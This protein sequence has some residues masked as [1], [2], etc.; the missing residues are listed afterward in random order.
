[1]ARLL[2][3]P[4]ENLFTQEVSTVKEVCLMAPFISS[5]G[6]D[7]LLAALGTSGVARV[8]TRL[9]D[10][11][12][13]SGV[14]SVGGLCRIVEQGSRVRA[15]NRRLHSKLYIFG[16]TSCVVT[17]SNLSTAGLSQ[18]AEIGVHLTRQA[19]IDSAKKHFELVWASLDPDTPL[20]EL[21]RIEAHVDL[22]QLRRG[23]R[24]DDP[25]GIVDHGRDG[26]IGGASGPRTPP[27]S[28]HRS[29][30]SSGR[31][32]CKFLWRR[33]DEA[34]LDTKVGLIAP[35]QG[36]VAFPRSGRPRQIKVNDHIYHTALTSTSRGRD[37]IVFGRARVAS[38]HRPGKDEAP[39]DLRRRIPMLD[40]YPYCIWL[41]DCEFIDGE[42]GDG[43]SLHD[44]FGQ[45][46]DST[47]EWS[48]KEA[49]E[50]RTGRHRQ[51]IAL[52][53]SHIALTRE[54]VATLNDEFDQRLS[55]HGRVL[56][57]SGSEIWWN[58]LIETVDRSR[59]FQKAT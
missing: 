43:V 21:R 18:N 37:W 59:R 39:T 5:Q 26:H 19:E 1:M 25:E 44:L 4:W 16:D 29:S 46:G 10:E 7:L 35:Y 20:T 42:I 40:S 53:R 32:F 11:D 51:A 52:N 56:I 17:S 49:S 33:K 9:N 48:K 55:Q 2:T 38:Q 28:T 22:I 8:I 50:G 27:P 54:A 6:A 41:C 24:Q 36:A 15:Q 45:H 34:P 30:E 31:H 47:F 14:S 57:R 12:F 3:G 58:E 13:L 23:G